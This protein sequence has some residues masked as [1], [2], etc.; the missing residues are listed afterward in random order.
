MSS[1]SQ[2]LIVLWHIVTKD[3]FIDGLLK[4]KP[5]D[6]S[7]TAAARRK[8]A[9]QKSVLSHGKSTREKAKQE[10]VLIYQKQ[11]DKEATTIEALQRMRKLKDQINKK[12]SRMNAQH[13]ANRAQ[14][15][16]EGRFTHND[17]RGVN[18]QVLTPAWAGK[19]NVQEPDRDSFRLCFSE[20]IHA[21]ADLMNV[22]ST[23]LCQTSCRLTLLH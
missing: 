4:D 22:H 3:G 23:P 10:S 12:Y 21:S 11:Q 19:L 7:G 2:T 14:A 13:Q 5:D 9:K 15:Q 20:M 16:N 1:Q 6:S 8:K 18:L 17:L